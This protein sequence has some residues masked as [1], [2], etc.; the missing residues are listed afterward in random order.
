MYFL[1]IIS[2]L[3]PIKKPIMGREKITKLILATTVFA[4]LISVFSQMFNGQSLN[5]ENYYTSTIIQPESEKTD[6]SDLKIPIF[7]YHHVR[8]IDDPNDPIGNYLT[9]TSKQFKNQLDLIESLGYTPVTFEELEKGIKPAK[10]IILTFDDSYIDFF[11]VA[12]PELKKRGLSAVLYVI[13]GSLGG[14]KFMN[15]DQVLEVSKNKI[16]IGSHTV[17]HPLYAV[18]LRTLNNTDL[19]KELVESKTTL[20]RL[21]NKEVIS[22]CYPGGKYSQHVSE[23]VEKFGYHYAVTVNPG[24][25]P[26][27]AP[28]D[29]NRYKVY[30]DTD[31][32]T[33]IK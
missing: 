12:Y 16:E 29:L 5:P 26:F 11:T 8:D 3:N 6:L 22:F 19:R 7:M 15:E 10:P 27:S 2:K 14:E 24:D 21:L 23:E 32:S 18:N 30:R 20:E 31:I 4:L 33:Y 28:F 25:A 1:R 17:T 9:S 13:T